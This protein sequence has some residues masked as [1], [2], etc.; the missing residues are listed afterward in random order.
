MTKPV[1]P[2]CIRRAACLL[3]AG[4]L[5]FL[6]AGAGAKE[7][8]WPA[9]PIRIVV[10]FAPGGLIDIIART[11]QPRLNEI[12]GQPVI[13]ENRPAAG[14]TVAEGAVARAVIFRRRLHQL[15]GR[16]ARCAGD[17]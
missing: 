3:L 11:F 4:S 5:L 17:S 12:F 1:L 15:T 16:N 7:E 13:I 9:K 6:H 8:A 2:A 10:A 14:G